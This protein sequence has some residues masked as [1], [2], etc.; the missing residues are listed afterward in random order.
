MADRI[1]GVVTRILDGDLFEIQVKEVLV[2]DPDAYDEF[3]LIRIA[4][5][6]DEIESHTD[7]L[8][9]GQPIDD[10]ETTG[11]PEEAAQ[12][13]GKVDSTRFYSIRDREDLEARLLTRVVE[14]R[15]LYREHTEQLIG[16]VEVLATADTGSDL[17]GG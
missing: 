13:T 8:E 15:V 11:T 17:Q 2:G 4:S 1:R 7:E 12:E 5:L 14:C 9:E 6:S 3:E 10:D 16:E